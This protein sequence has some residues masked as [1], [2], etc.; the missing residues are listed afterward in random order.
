V[1]PGESEICGDK[2]DNDCDGK[3]DKGTPEVCNGIDQCAAGKCLTACGRDADCVMGLH[4]VEKKCEGGQNG[5]R[6]SL[7]EQCNSGSCAPGGVCGGRSDADC[8]CS[9]IEGICD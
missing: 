1:H 9:C 2:L 8:Q 4:C 7:D 3:V 6:C 5:A